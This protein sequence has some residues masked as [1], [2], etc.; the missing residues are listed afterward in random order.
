MA[1]IYIRNDLGDIPLGKIMAQ[2]CHAYG[3]LWIERLELQNY[4]FLT[5]QA[6]RLTKPALKALDLAVPP[7]VQYCS[8]EEL[9]NVPDIT[10]IKDAGLTVFKEPTITCGAVA[11]ELGP[12][13]TKPLIHHEHNT[14]FCKQAIFINRK[15]AI[16][17]DTDK[18]ISETAFASAQTLLRRI[19]PKNG[20]LTLIRGEPLD[21]WIHG[22]FGKTVVG[23][24]KPTK[25]EEMKERFDE[26]DKFNIF[27]QDAGFCT[28]P[29]QSDLIEDYTRTK[30]F[31]LLDVV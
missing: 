30:H 5:S 18:L 23:T 1:V 20:L 17:Q 24:K 27:D 10:L 15:H 2:A 21:H 6:Y 12:K 28:S 4:W 16:A 7:T 19:R 13:S 8:L 14:R 25:M 22:R 31:R 29:I 26:E 9:M 3:K 11:P